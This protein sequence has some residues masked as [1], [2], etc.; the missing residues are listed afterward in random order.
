MCIGISYIVDHHWWTFTHKRVLDIHTYG[1]A[2]AL[3]NGEVVKSRSNDRTNQ[4]L[5]IMTTARTYVMTEKLRLCL[6]TI[7]SH[8]V[9]CR[10]HRYQLELFTMDSCKHGDTSDVL[11]GRL[12]Y[13]R[14]SWQRHVSRHSVLPRLL[15][16]ANRKPPSHMT[17]KMP[18]P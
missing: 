12:I 2:N 4:H 18:L 7:R 11:N 17:W 6:V 8:S 13:F 14:Y 3:M 5:I 16:P 9:L 15:W 10:S 1:E